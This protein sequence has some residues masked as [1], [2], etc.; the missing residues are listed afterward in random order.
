MRSLHRLLR[1]RLIWEYHRL[2]CRTTELVHLLGITRAT[3]QRAVGVAESQPVAQTRHTLTILDQWFFTAFWHEVAGRRGVD[4]PTLGPEFLRALCPLCPSL[5]PLA[6]DQAQQTPA[7]ARHGAG[8]AEGAPEFLVDVYRAAG[9][10]CSRARRP[11]SCLTGAARFLLVCD[12]LSR[13]PWTAALFITQHVSKQR[14]G[15]RTCLR[16]GGRFVSPSPAIKHCGCPP[17]TTS[18]GPMTLTRL[19]RTELSL[20]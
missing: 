8:A 18:P 1:D 9:L 3:I 19:A 11:A 14:C 6:P 2:G 15:V 20:R 17:E 12:A 7:S 4:P 16:C 13:N 10:L 5:T